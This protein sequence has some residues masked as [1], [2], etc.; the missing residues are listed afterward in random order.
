MHPI[1]LADK[2]CQHDEAHTI[3][4]SMPRLQHLEMGYMM[5]A[6]EAVLEIL[7]QCRKLKGEKEERGRMEYGRRRQRPRK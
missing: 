3:A 2:V 7:G 4:R 6:T 1:D 5:V